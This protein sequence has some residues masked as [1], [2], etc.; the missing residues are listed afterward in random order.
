MSRGYK[1]AFVAALLGLLSLT[2]HAQPCL[3]GWL[4]RKAI[5]VNNLDAASNNV[6]VNYTFDG[7]ALLT[8]GKLKIDGGDI[9]FLDN[10]GNNLDYW[11]ERST[12]NSNLSQVWIKIA[13]LPVGISTIYM[14]YGNSSGVPIS[15]G[16][17]V[18]TFFDDFSGGSLNSNLWST[19]KSADGNIYQSGGN[20]VLQTANDQQAIITSK[21]TF[22]SNHKLEVKISGIDDADAFAGLT[23]NNS[24]GYMIYYNGQGA[25]KTMQLK[26]AQAAGGAC[27]TLNSQMPSPDATDAYNTTGVWQFWWE[28]RGLQKLDW[29]GSLLNPAE[30]NDNTFDRPTQAKVNLGV[31]ATNGTVRVD[32]VRMKPVADPNV[33]FFTGSEEVVGVTLSASSNGPLCS[34]D[35]MQLLVNGIPGATYVWNGPNGFTSAVQNPVLFNVSEKFS[36]NYQVQVAGVSNCAS[37][38]AQVNVLIS[39]SSEPGNIS[40]STNVCAV[41]N[42]GE[43][44]V[45]GYVGNITRWESSNAENSPWTT[46]NQTADIL[47]Y[48]DIAQTTKYRAII[49]SGTCAEVP[50]N[51]ATINVDAASKGGY[52]AGAGSICPGN[53][54]TDLQLADFVGDIAGWQQSSD[55]INWNTIN[56]GNAKITVDNL[57]STTFFQ[58][59]V[60]NGICPATMSTVFEL[61]TNPLPAIDFNFSSQCAGHQVGFVNQSSISK[62]FISS[63]VWDFGE[64]GSSVD[65]SPDYIFDENGD[66]QVTLK[67]FTDKGCIDSLKKTIQV[68]ALPKPQFS[69]DNACEGNDVNFNNASSISSGTITSYQWMFDQLGSS[70]SINPQFQFNASGDFEVQ[71]KAFSNY[72]CED[73]IQKTIRIYPRSNLDF[74]IENACLGQPVKFINNSTS[75]TG[76]LSFNWDFGDSNTSS[77][78]NPEHLYTGD[79]VYQVT[80][81]ATSALSC[82]DEKSKNITIYPQPNAAFDVQNVCIYDSAVYDNQSFITNGTLNYYWQ[83]GDGNFSYD[84]N[85]K[86]LYKKAGSYEVSLEIASAFG[87]KD[88]QSKFIDIL[89]QPKAA[90]IADNSC[91][92]EPVNFQNL[93]DD[94]EGYFYSWNFGDGNFSNQLNPDHLYNQDDLYQATLYVA[95]DE[96]CQDSVSR[97]IEVY[98]LPQPSFTVADVCDGEITQFENTSTIASGTINNYLWNF[99]DGTNAVIE[100]PAKQYLNPGKYQVILATTSN[101][102]CRASTSGE[103]VVH[104]IPL[105]R[106]TAEN[107]CS[108]EEVIF[109]NQSDYGAGDTFSWAFGDGNTS[110]ETSPRYLY[111]DPGNYE[112]KLGI[113]SREGCQDS[114]YQPLEV[115]A[116]AFTSVSADTSVSKGYRVELKATGGIRYLWEP[117]DWL[118]NSD[119]S[120]PVATPLETTTFSVFI[121]DKN[122]CRVERQVTV[123]VLE[124]YRVVP[125]NVMTPDGNGENDFWSV[126][127][128]ESYPENEISIYNRWGQEV[129]R[130][131]NYGND[132][133][134]TSGK[135]ILPDG[136]Y[137]YLIRFANQKEKYIGALSILRNKR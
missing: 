50:S 35:D 105:A 69:F 106:F 39:P 116:P 41:D 112:V 20:L 123:E 99:G 135:D 12:L 77:Q 43:I 36:G 98:P 31:V 32:W 103:A 3:S 80:L 128:I 17:K 23:D 81:K 11:L 30:R 113:I 133:Y 16:D 42:K 130:Q 5:E 101:Q 118:N 18:F 57:T 117:I 25:T 68:Y 126:W 52:I 10:N 47:D 137:Y 14:F 110:Q 64:G 63:Y 97:S 92:G 120:N 124:D 34:G 2:T 109:I 54:S 8:A 122:N 104:E 79:G 90:F 19:C 129:Y 111:Q 21:N 75:A 131:S 45:T 48:E 83:Y 26:V 46:I 59:I 24:R 72:G 93:T 15:S 115:Y 29:P 119:I 78:I 125:S 70:S 108:G 58:A 84:K 60:Q 136:T 28:S 33:N 73:S 53:N 76:G 40:G 71:L 38:I 1:I 65:Q 114:I 13:S 96:G 74:E 107:V 89:P 134:G 7:K 94:E 85:P 88:S 100:D 87:C 127:N 82:I 37:V 55:Q 49:K 121:T 132:W 22:N 9:R 95:S 86:Y 91:L 102:G 6:V 44:N 56:S 4:Y 27:L 62:G 66:F 51:S 67:A 61:V